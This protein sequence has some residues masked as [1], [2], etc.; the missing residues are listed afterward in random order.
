MTLTLIQARDLLNGVGG[1]LNAVDVSMLA[2]HIKLNIPPVMRSEKAFLFVLKRGRQFLQ[3]VQDEEK[4]AADGVVG[5]QLDDKNASKGLVGK[6]FASAEPLRLRNPAEEE[7][8]YEHVDGAMGYL[9]K[10][11]L[12]VPVIWKPAEGDLSGQEP[13]CLGVLGVVNKAADETESDWFGD[14]DVKLM[15]EIGSYVATAVKN[16][17]DHE[18]DS[19]T[20]A[21]QAAVSECGPAVLGDLYDPEMPA[22][23][24]AARDVVCCDMVHIHCVNPRDGSL[25]LVSKYLNGETQ[26]SLANAAMG[27]AWDS[28][29]GIQKGEGLVG[30]CLLE[31]A[32][33]IAP[34]CYADDRFEAKKDQRG[35]AQCINMLCLPLRAPGEA[36]KVIGVLQLTNKTVG[37]G[38]DEFDIL[39][40]EAFAKDVLSIALNNLLSLHP[41]PEEDAPAGE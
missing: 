22:A 27:G 39:W 4:D 21:V 28:R 17:N 16:A 15:E 38:F 32:T 10:N 5:V 25:Q 40:G 7:D 36:P 2:E 3:L 26:P 41:P 9:P 31:D 12:V 29:A 8:Y 11:L 18:E 19:L 23:I 33:I 6:C 1:V 34:N 20:L 13:R 37:D 14:K 30:S 24:R 35:K